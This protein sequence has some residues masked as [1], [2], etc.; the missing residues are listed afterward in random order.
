MKS[1]YQGAK[2][3][4]TVD[5]PSASRSGATAAQTS[6]FFTSLE[7]ALERGAAM[8]STAAAAKPMAAMTGA[9]EASITGARSPPGPR[10]GHPLV[11][12]AEDGRRQ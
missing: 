1:M 5:M 2:T 8:I 4:S 7:Y 9:P 11:R 3:L 12:V 6:S 10:V